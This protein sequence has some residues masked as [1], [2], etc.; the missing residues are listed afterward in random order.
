MDRVFKLI[1]C[2]LLMCVSNNKVKT[3]ASQ[4]RTMNVTIGSGIFLVIGL[5]QLILS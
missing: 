1:I 5:A 4:N 3:L 2:L